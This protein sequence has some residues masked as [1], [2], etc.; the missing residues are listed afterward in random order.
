MCSGNMMGCGKTHKG[1]KPVHGGSNEIMTSC[2]WA[3]K[4]VAEHGKAGNVSYGR[5]NLCLYL[6]NH[7]H[8]WT[9]K[10]S[11]FAFLKHVQEKMYVFSCRWKFIQI[12]VSKSATIRRLK[13]HSPLYVLFCMLVYCL[14]CKQLCMPFW[15]GDLHC[16]V[17]RLCE[18]QRKVVFRFVLEML[19]RSAHTECHLNDFWWQ[20]LLSPHCE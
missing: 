16:K 6:L 1:K 20:F 14:Y 17:Q 19:I 5:A 15:M 18:Y 3:G 12:F 7:S 13:E 8:F 2:R 10:Q 9:K 11:P 4:L